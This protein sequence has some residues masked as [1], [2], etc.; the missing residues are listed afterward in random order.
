M[1][2]CLTIDTIKNKIK[3]H[4]YCI[5]EHVVRFIINGKI[6]V[7]QIEKAVLSGKII[8][9]HKHPMRGDSVLILG[10]SDEKPVH[11]ICTDNMND[12][13]M[14]LF[15]YFPTLPVWKTSV[16]R[17]KNG[18][19]YVKNNAGKCFFCGGRVEK[20]HFGSFDYRLDGELYVI[21]N[22]PAGLCAQCGEKYISAESAK[23]INKLIDKGSY[24]ETGKVYII[25]Y[26]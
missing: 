26:E 15:V 7:A 5:S 8:E 17:N 2:S 4:E 13:L 21:K 20:I 22:I 1:D 14:F 25:N 9:H 16:H 24:S 12:Y 10:N 19:I 18:D 23:K 11:V 3:K 6:S